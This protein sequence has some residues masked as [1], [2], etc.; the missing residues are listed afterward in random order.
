MN[1]KEKSTNPQP[2]WIDTILDMLRDSDDGSREMILADCGKKCYEDSGIVDKIR[3]LAELK[4]G[5]AEEQV[6]SLIQR[7]VFG[8]DED[9]PKIYMQGDIICIK[10]SRCHC[11]L[12]SEEHNNNGELCECTCSFAKSLIESAFNRDSEVTLLKSINRGDDSCLLG[13]KLL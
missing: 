10:Y 2:G 4:E 5:Q 3:E 8:E 13:I 9:S 11:R 7:E 12:V 1:D 6:L